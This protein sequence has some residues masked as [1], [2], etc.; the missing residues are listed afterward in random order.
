M[1]WL[2]AEASNRRIVALNDE[3]LVLNQQLATRLAQLAEARTVN[4][5]DVSTLLFRLVAAQEN[6]RARIAR[7]LH[8]HLGQ[9]LTVLRLTLERGETERAPGSVPSASLATALALL[10]KIEKD[11]DFLGWQLRPAVL[12]ELGL[13]AALPRFVAQWSELTGVQAEYR[14]VALGDGQLPKDAEVA[15]YR[16]AQEALNN[17]VKHAAAGRVDVVLGA[18]DTEVTLVIEDDG[19]GFEAAA[20]PEQ[21]TGF[22]LAGIRERAALVGATLAIESSPGEGTGI[23]LRCPTA[24]RPK[25]GR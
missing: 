14:G 7:D 10:Q 5:G 19:I 20:L 16:I 21:T 17:I 8:D 3:I 23:F 12:D 1:E 18:T 25:A 15:F 11:V 2:R 4:Q 9:Q 6:E 22:G 13:S 24:P